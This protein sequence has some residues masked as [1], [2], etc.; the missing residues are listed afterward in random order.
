VTGS[1]IIVV[2]VGKSVAKAILLN[3]DGEIIARRTH[4]N[5]SVS[6]Q[7]LAV[8]DVDGIDGWLAG[9]LPQLLALAPVGSIVPVAHGAAAAIVEGGSLKMPPL[10]YE[11]PLPAALRMA[12]DEQRDPF[13][14]TGS[15]RLPDGLNLGAQLHFLETRDPALIAGDAQI[16]PW[17]QYWGWRLSGI[18]ASEMT[19]LGCHTDLWL[20]MARRPSRL[21]ERRGWE[22]R[23]AP[24]R[25]AHEI[26]GPLR[27]PWSGPRAAGPPIKILCGLHDSN[28]ALLAARGL[29]EIGQSEATVLSTGTWFV[30]MRSPS[31]G[32]VIDP[33]MLDEARDCLINVDVRGGP[34]PSARFMGGREAQLLLGTD[35]VSLDDPGVQPETRRAASEVIAAE[36]MVLPTTVPGVG[37]FPDA[38][39]RW[40]GRP[41]SAMARASAIALYLALVADFALDL[42]GARDRIL[43]EGRFGKSEIFVRALAALRPTTAVLVAEGDLDLAFG[44]ARLANP[45][46][47]PP[48]P[49][50]RAEP[51]EQCLESY[52][53]SWRQRLSSGVAG[54]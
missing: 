54:R 7:G 18:A 48:C 26:L 52:R 13:A 10:D 14:D 53:A 27:M 9:V 1:G 34:T 8:L 17:A 31:S 19:S 5:S 51:L 33:Q 11:Q 16:V 25:G 47:T 37:P 15:P 2:D 24:L 20:P 30:A 40:I 22:R 50:V 21:A 46:L 44:A 42:I 12:Y 32:T 38:D 6:W 35:A 29:P 4:P 36:S 28:A 23:L 45:E 41:D 49:L 3:G 39:G 43:V